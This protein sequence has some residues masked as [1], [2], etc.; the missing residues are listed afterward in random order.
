[1]V[2]VTY[3]HRILSKGGLFN[4]ILFEMSV[5]VSLSFFSSKIVQQVMQNLFI[6][7]KDIIF[8][9]KC[10]LAVI[11]PFLIN[12]FEYCSSVGSKGMSRIGNKLS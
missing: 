8:N 7:S 11:G 3:S 10:Y 1:M 12:T 6:K 5:A 9:L 2:N 4:D